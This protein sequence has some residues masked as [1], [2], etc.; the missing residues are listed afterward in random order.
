MIITPSSTC[1]R[2]ADGDFNVMPAPASRYLHNYTNV[3]RYTS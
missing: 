2:I 3:L 1:R